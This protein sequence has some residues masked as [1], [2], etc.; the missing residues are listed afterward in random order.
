MTSRRSLLATVPGLLL[1]S[2]AWAGSGNAV[3]LRARPGKP[4]GKAPG[5]GVRSLGVRRNRDAQLY[6]P[7]S[8]AGSD[9]PAPF[10]VYLHG[11]TGSEQQG[12]RR[13]SEFSESLGFVLLS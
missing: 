3:R 4:S 10:L 12:I 2:C 9:K 6:V 1:S 8:V 11:A 7:K 5:P 13:L